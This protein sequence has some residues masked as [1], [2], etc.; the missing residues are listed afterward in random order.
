MPMLHV[1]PGAPLSPPHA[2]LGG[3]ECPVCGLA[4]GGTTSGCLR[5]RNERRQA[6]GGHV[7]PTTWSKTSGEYCLVARVKAGVGFKK[8]RSG[9]NAVWLGASQAASLLAGRRGWLEGSLRLS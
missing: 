7:I 9:E 6:R 8:T 4:P 1:S 3:F 2:L 5:P